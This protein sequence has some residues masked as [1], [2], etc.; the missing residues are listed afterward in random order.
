MNLKI[1]A[2]KIIILVAVALCT[3]LGV[4]LGLTIAKNHDLEGKLS[5][6]REEGL[7]NE[8]TIATLTKDGKSLEEKLKASEDALAE[9]DTEL[10]ATKAALEAVTIKKKTK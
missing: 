6:A 5:V 9:M 2:Q 8:A 10:T 3:G 1:D 4:G 7:A